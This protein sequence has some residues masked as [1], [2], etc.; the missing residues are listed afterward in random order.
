MGRYLDARTLIW[1]MSADI[2]FLTATSEFTL[3]TA[4]LDE[5]FISMAHELPTPATAPMLLV[6]ITV[7]GVRRRSRLQAA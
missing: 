5:N 6:L 3:D 2:D 7:C 4:S 1:E